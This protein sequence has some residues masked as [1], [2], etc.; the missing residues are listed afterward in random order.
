MVLL[1]GFML[2]ESLWDDVVDCFKLD[3]PI[4]R[5]PLAPG[6]TIGEIAEGIARAAPERFVLVGF[7]LG[8]YVARKLAELFPR[9]VAALILV[10]SSLRPDTDEQARSKRVLISSLSAET[11]QGLSASSISG[12]LHPDHRTNRDLILKIKEMGARLGYEALVTQVNLRRDDI[13]A[14][15]LACPT[16]VIAAA[17]DPLRSADENRELIAAIPN[18]S[19]T[20]IQGTGHMIPLE[21]P[22]ALAEEIERWLGVLDFQ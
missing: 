18:A 5:P 11:F 20:V 9:R 12:S 21:Q 13:A 6:A 1:P 3:R 7:S 4:Y 17:D 10:G 15:T 2:D 16:L 8:G 22:Q 19:F 14:S